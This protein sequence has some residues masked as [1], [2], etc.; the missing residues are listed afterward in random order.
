MGAD[1]R[2]CAAGGSAAVALVLLLACSNVAS[3]LLARAS[4]RRR[5]L[6]VRVALGA[7]RGRLV[8]QLLTE[9]LL[10][11]CLAGLLGVALA[12]LA[13]K[14]VLAFQP[15]LPF[16]L[17]LGLELD[18]RVLLF[19]LAL[20]LVTGAGRS[21]ADDGGRGDLRRGERARGGAELHRGHRALRA[22]AAGAGLSGAH[23]D[24]RR[25]LR[26]ERAHG[27]ARLVA[28]AG[29]LDRVVEEPATSFE[30][31]FDQL[32]EADLVVATRFHN[33]LSALLLDK[34]VV[35]VSHM[36]KNDQ[37]MAS[38]EL[39]E[40]C[41]PLAN[42]ELEPLIARFREL[43]RNAEPLRE[44]IRAKNALF[45]QQLESQYALLFGASDETS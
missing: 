4:L 41:M 12:A 44:R 30:M 25:G 3:L 24:R 13:L 6:A 22:V 37:L 34:P 21:G 11:A 20:S 35:S 23:R 36:D 19:A 43:E 17:A 40:Y 8:R 27:A 45:R 7:R 15:P 5:E 39:S 2:P 18:R 33:V 42:V 32:A 26:P 16:T 1:D 9:S 14:L 28:D 29:A 10:P 31:L 38:M